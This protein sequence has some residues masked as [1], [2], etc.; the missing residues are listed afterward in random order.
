VSL[1]SG[2]STIE[3]LQSLGHQTSLFDFPRDIP[4]FLQNY[5]NLDFVFLIIHGAGGEDGQIASFLDVLGLKYHCTN[6][7]VLHLT[8]NKW[9]T[10]QVR[11]QHGVPVAHDKL[12]N[13][14]TKIP[15]F[16]G[17]CVI[18]ALDQGS[19][20]G[21]WICKDAKSFHEALHEAK[22]YSTVMIEEFLE[23]QECTVAVIDALDG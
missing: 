15:I 5:K 10:K 14:S 20:V 21:V 23:G 12:I 8:M 1:R 9:L 3:A 13:L 2:Q 7:E 22:I 4:G 17:P 11:L 6:P 16:E 19:S 18:K